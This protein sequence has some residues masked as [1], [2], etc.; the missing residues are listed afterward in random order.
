[1]RKHRVRSRA[2]RTWLPSLRPLLFLGLGR[3]N[4]RGVALGALL[5]LMARTLPRRGKRTSTAS[6]AKEAVSF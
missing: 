2:M 5:A 3:S 1:M 4:L 6:H